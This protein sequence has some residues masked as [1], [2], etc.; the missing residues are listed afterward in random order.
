MQ[1]TNR[2]SSTLFYGARNKTLMAF[3]DSFSEWESLG[4]KVVP[5]FSQDGNGYVQEVF[6]SGKENLLTAPGTTGVVLCGQ[7]EMCEA[8]TEIMTG[9]GVDKDKIIL[10][11]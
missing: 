3:D 7:K 8:I 4:V 10:N 11:F 9:S 5:V 2:S 1:A 6:E